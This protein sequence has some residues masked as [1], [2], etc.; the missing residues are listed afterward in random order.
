MRSTIFVND[1][2]S[3]KWKII[4][5]RKYYIN[6]IIVVFKPLNERA[7]ENF[8]GHILQR[9]DFSPVWTDVMC[10]SRPFFLCF[11]KKLDENIILYMYNYLIVTS[12]CCLHTLK[13]D[14]QNVQKCS[15]DRCTWR[16]CL[17][18]EYLFKK[19]LS[20]F[21]HCNVSILECFNLLCSRK[22]FFV[23]YN[24][25]HFSHW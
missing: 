10:S 16:T 13:L 24:L 9:K 11:I 2:V 7:V 8:E 12:K 22:Y 15:L 4:C 20:H 19:Y 6:K 25:L 18:N 23:L 17:F 14:P 21:K 3:Y 5:N 1:L